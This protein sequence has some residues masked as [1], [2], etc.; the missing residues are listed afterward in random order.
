MLS[1]VTLYCQIN[2]AVMIWGSQLSETRSVWASRP[3]RLPC[4]VFC[5]FLG[6]EVGLAIPDICQVVPVEK[7]CHAEKFQISLY[8]RL[9]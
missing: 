6:T 5:I 8:D 1:S 7:I 9:L 2:M 3:S 4:Y